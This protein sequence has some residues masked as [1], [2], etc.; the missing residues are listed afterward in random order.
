VIERQ[1]CITEAFDPI[2]RRRVW[3]HV[4]EE[5]TPAVGQRRRDIVRPARLRWLQGRRSGSE[6]WDAYDRPDGAS[7]V[8]KRGH[9]EPWETA[10]VWLSDLADELHAS[11]RDGTIPDALSQG[12]VWITTSG[13]AVLLDF[14]SPGCATESAHPIVNVE[15]VQAF[16]HDAA[17]AT[18]SPLMPVHARTFLTGLRERRFEAP[19]I[20]AGNLRALVNRAATAEPRRRAMSAFFV[21]I[22]LA[23]VLV[24]FGAI[25]FQARRDFDQNWTR[26]NP[27]VESPR[28]ALEVMT[29]LTDEG[30]EDEGD[31]HRPA[32]TRYLA[33]NYGMRVVGDPFW[34]GKEADALNSLGLLIREAVEYYIV[35]DLPRIAHE[36]IPGAAEIEG[37]ARVE[38][39]LQRQ[40]LRRSPWLWVLF[41]AVLASAVACI[42][43]IFAALFFRTSPMLRLFGFAVV[44]HDGS[45]AERWRITG[46]AIL[47]A[48]PV[49]L[50]SVFLIRMDRWC[51][52]LER[53]FPVLGLGLLIT[54]SLFWLA[55][56]VAT[57]GPAEKLTGSWIVPR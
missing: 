28:L 35:A 2:L 23:A 16:L 12:Y 41:Y 9:C 27:G 51:W 22:V 7:L 52:D 4:V 36:P 55:G 30:D 57:R 47:A 50:A 45:P 54:V 11:L 13:R 48:A 5:G 44:R 19:P 3:I 10:R 49:F 21:P 17:E 29:D 15:Q 14:P 33:R 6:N 34:K 42:I 40:A 37:N 46:R 25:L 39:L 8:E 53:S 32:L 38:T 43:G 56:L 24:L 26:E 20:V 1:G 31:E 18:I